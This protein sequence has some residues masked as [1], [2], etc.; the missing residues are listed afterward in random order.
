MKNPTRCLVLVSAVV[1][2]L[3][4][5]PI[6]FAQDSPNT[7]SMAPVC[8]GSFLNGSSSYAPKEIERTGPVTG[9]SSGPLC[10]TGC[11]GQPIDMQCT[12]PPTSPNATGY[13]ECGTW[14][15]DCWFL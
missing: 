3:T 8:H 5:A 13:A 6:T 1:L 7:L 10:S 4:A 2:S 15:A 12:C 9:L 11:S 14:R